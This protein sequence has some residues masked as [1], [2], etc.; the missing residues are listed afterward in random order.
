LGSGVIDPIP[1]QGAWR[2]RWT[3]TEEHIVTHFREELATVMR[4]ASDYL[5]TSS[6]PA[7]FS[8]YSQPEPLDADQ[9]TRQATFLQDM[10]QGPRGSCARESWFPDGQNDPVHKLSRELA[11]GV[12]AMR[13]TAALRLIHGAR[14]LMDTD[15]MRAC[16]A[17][18]LMDVGEY[19]EGNRLARAC[20][21]PRTDPLVR[22]SAW[23]IIAQSQ[24]HLGGPGP[25][26]EP[27][28]RA[29]Q[30]DPRSSLYTLNGLLCSLQ[31]G[32]A[33][34]AAFATDILNGNA[35]WEDAAAFNYASFHADSIHDGET[36][37][38]TVFH[39]TLSRIEGLF[40]PLT[41][42]LTNEAIRSN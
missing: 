32:D 20:T 17:K 31:S 41:W 18:A 6:N 11:R 14:R 4:A 3:P 27:Y 9:I 42:H 39:S 38:S 35:E 30:L 1:I 25:A 24:E 28:L 29:A 23:S 33:P 26:V 10:P 12:E 22:A 19:Y 37:L 5:I 7:D 34:S 8:H 40:G 16:H 36:T 13:P 2:E 15:A 21:T